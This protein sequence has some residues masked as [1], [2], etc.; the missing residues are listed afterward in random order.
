MYI[1]GLHMGIFSS[2]ALWR[3]RTT[4]F[5]TVPQ[6]L[7]DPSPRIS[8]RA[9]GDFEGQFEYGHQVESLDDGK[10]YLWSI[11]TGISKVGIHSRCIG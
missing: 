3:M 1:M 6:N 8:V 11:E 4:H 9:Y 5:S 7:L 10:V 2:E